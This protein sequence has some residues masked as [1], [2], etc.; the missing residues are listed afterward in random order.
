MKAIAGFQKRQHP[1]A[2]KEVRQFNN[3]IHSAC[4]TNQRGNNE[5]ERRG[6]LRNFHQRHAG[7]EKYNHRD[8]LHK[9]V[10]GDDFAHILFCC[11]ILNRGIQRH[12]YKAAAHAKEQRT[13]AKQPHICV[14]GKD[15][16]CDENAQCADGNDAMLNMVARHAARD[17]RAD[18]HAHAGQRQNALHDNGVI[19]AKHLFVMRRKGRHYHL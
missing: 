17:C 1:E 18:N 4:Q 11:Q 9:I 2:R 15:H 3:G 7:G 10:P 8:V 6:G 19:V 14:R 16:Q 5:N 13:R 12:E